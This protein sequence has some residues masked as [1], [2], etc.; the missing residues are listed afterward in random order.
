MPFCLPPVFCR[1]FFRERGFCPV[2]LFYRLVEIFY[3][4]KMIAGFFLLAF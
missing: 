4:G 1:T 3:N 2:F